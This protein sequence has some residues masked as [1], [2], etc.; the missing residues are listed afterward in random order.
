MCTLWNVRVNDI[1]IFVGCTPQI[2]IGN[3]V[4]KTVA[5]WVSEHR[6]GLLSKRINLSPFTKD[7]RG[8]G[9]SMSLH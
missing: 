4:Y 2:A 6:S 8:R 7:F 5:V 9:H 1:H 3:G